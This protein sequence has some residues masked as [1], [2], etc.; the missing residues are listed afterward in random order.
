MEDALEVSPY[1]SASP[2]ET[3]VDIGTTFGR[4]QRATASDIDY[5][6]DLSV[7]DGKTGVDPGYAVAQ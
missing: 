5:M 3:F 1:P 2:H 4:P 7:I 6:Y